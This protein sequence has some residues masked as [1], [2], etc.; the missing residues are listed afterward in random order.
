MLTITT[1]GWILLAVVVL[2]VLSAA[3]VAVTV[4]A[5]DAREIIAADTAV[6]VAFLLGPIL[7]SRYLTDIIWMVLLSA[8]LSTVL[9]VAS[10]FV[11]IRRADQPNC[12]PFCAAYAGFYGLSAVAAMAYIVYRGVGN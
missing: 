10:I 2:A 6:C 12:V 8:V 1:R 3:F 11:A 7:A 9:S 5:T 4:C